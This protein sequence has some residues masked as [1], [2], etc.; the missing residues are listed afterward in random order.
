VSSGRSVSSKDPGAGG[1]PQGI[2]ASH[3]LRLGAGD[4]HYG[5]GLVAGGRL[6][7]LLGDLATELCVASDGDEGL[8]AAYHSVEFLLPVHAGDFIEVRG[9]ISGAGRTS[10]RMELVVLRYARPRADISDSAVDLLDEPEVVAKAGCT[11]VVGK[12]KQRRTESGQEME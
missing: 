2:T 6:M 11:C 7:E 3:R 8:L 4:A 5:G 10:R 9:S 1:A 12:D